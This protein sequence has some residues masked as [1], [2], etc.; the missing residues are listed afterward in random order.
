MNGC[1]GRD[2]RSD[3]KLYQPGFPH[4]WQQVILYRLL[5]VEVKHIRTQ[6]VENRA[7]LLLS[8]T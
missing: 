8:R 2:Q 1:P 7:S 6:G 5:L 3:E 4:M